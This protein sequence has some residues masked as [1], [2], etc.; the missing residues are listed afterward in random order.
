[1]FTRACVQPHLQL[2]AASVS[3]LVCNS[4]PGVVEVVMGN[5]VARV[6]YKSCATLV[7]TS[8]PA[9]TFGTVRVLPVPGDSG[10]GSCSSLVVNPYGSALPAT[11]L[12][13]LAVLPRDTALSGPRVEFTPFS[14]SQYASSI[15]MPKFNYAPGTRIALEARATSTPCLPTRPRAGSPLRRSC[16]PPAARS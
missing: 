2:Q 8:D 12:L 14:M 15:V 16:S 4:F 7:D 9:A 5:G 3:Y 10:S 6:A 1:M 13:L 11:T